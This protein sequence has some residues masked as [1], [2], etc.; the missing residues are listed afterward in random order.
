M[1][2][3]GESPFA[4]PIGIIIRQ[5]SLMGTKTTRRKHVEKKHI[6]IVPEDHPTDYTVIAK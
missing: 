1:Q 4:T 3:G 5:A 6:L 2:W